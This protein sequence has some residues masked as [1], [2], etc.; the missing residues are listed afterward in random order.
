VLQEHDALLW[1]AVT[2]H[3]N[4]GPSLKSADVEGAALV[5]GRVAI[6]RMST[7]NKSRLL[8]KGIA[9]LTHSKR[10]EKIQE[11]VFNHQEAT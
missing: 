2:I 8:P 5:N 10:K 3:S 4:H 9:H 6:Q 11:I 1:A 7:V